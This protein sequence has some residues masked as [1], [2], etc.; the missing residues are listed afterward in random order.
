GSRSALVDRELDLD[1]VAPTREHA[2]D[3]EQRLGSGVERSHVHLALE[4]VR[5]AHVTELEVRLHVASGDA[6]AG[7][8]FASVPRR[9]SSTTSSRTFSPDFWA[10]AAST[11]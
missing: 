4:P 6:I 1:A 10:A 5:A 7:A 3:L 2:V 8:P 11:V 9:L